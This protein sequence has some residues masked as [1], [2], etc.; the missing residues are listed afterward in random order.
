MHDCASLVIVSRRPFSLDCLTLENQ[1]KGFLTSTWNH[2]PSSTVSYPTRPESSETTFWEPQITQVILLRKRV[3]CTYFK[4]P[5]LMKQMTKTSSSFYFFYYYSEIVL[6]LTKLNKYF[7]YLYL[8]CFSYI[9]YPLVLQV[10]TRG[11]NLETRHLLNTTK[12]YCQY[13]SVLSA[14]SP[15]KQS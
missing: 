15:P 8:L 6:L 11:I 13:Q 9:I 12:F 10:L 3:A 2:S 1:G 5:M 7:S 14:L 4:K